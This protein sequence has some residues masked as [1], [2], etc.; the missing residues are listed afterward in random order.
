M[1]STSLASVPI[2]GTASD[3]VGV[4]L[5]YWSTSTGASGTAIGTTSWSFTAPVLVGSNTVTISARDAAGNVAWRT[6][7]VSRH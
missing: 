5:V 7:V 1:L 4:T 2:T 6:V 3:N